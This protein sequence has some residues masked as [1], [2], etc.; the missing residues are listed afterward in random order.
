MSVSAIPNIPLVTKVINTGLNV[1]STATVTGSINVGKINRVGLHLKE[2]SGNHAGVIWRMYCSPDNTNWFRTT[3]LGVAQVN[4]QNTAE[5]FDSSG[6]QFVRFQVDTA[7]G[8][9]A[10]ED[11]TIMA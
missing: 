7:S 10:T 5:S 2:A 8:V 3:Q 6:T 11:T 4:N 1:N 9:A